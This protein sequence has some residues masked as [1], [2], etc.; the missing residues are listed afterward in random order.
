MLQD[1]R[2]SSGKCLLQVQDVQDLKPSD[3]VQFVIQTP[4]ART[5]EKHAVRLKRI[6]VLH[7]HWV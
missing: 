1:V 4:N 3:I 5:K 7:L 6:K 2:Y